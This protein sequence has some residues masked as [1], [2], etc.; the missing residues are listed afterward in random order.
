MKS[1]MHTTFICETGLEIGLRLAIPKKK[2]LREKKKVKKKVR[3]KVNLKLKNA[4]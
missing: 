3:K 1:L 4:V 2:C